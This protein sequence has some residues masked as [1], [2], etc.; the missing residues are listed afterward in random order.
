VTAIQA[1]FSATA[2]AVVVAIALVCVGVAMLAGLGW[3][4]IT[5]GALIG[6]CAV[7]LAVALLHDAEASG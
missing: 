7:A 4:L 5:A 2:A 1:V 6:P 3:A